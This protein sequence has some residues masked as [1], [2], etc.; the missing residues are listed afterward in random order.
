MKKQDHRIHWHI[1][2]EGMEGKLRYKKEFN[3]LSAFPAGT[4][5]RALESVS[6]TFTSCNT[7]SD[8]VPTFSEVAGENTY[9]RVRATHS[10]GST[11]LGQ[12]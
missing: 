10:W 7:Q 9:L 6:M 5:T 2:T 11:E 3:H 8:E 4:T 1:V 12:H